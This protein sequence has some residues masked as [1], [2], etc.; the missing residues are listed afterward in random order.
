L[1]RS[2]T[3]SQIKS[4]LHGFLSGLLKTLPG[5]ELGQNIIVF[6]RFIRD[7]ELNKAV[8]IDE[9]GEVSINPSELPSLN[10]PEVVRKI[11]GYLGD[12]MEPNLS[13]LYAKLFIDAYEET[14]S[15]SQP[16]AD[17]WLG[18][19]MRDYGGLLSAYGVVDKLSREVNLPS[20]FKLMRP[21]STHLLKEEKP[22]ESYAM[23]KEAT[24]YGFR[25]VCVSKLEPS[26]V[27]YRYGLKNV[28]VIWLT[29][30]KTKEKTVSPD[31]LGELK[32]LI[33]NT[34]AGSV[35]L[36]D[37]LKEIKV[38]NGFKKAVD[39]L[40]EIIDL[41]V[42]NRLVLVVSIDPRSFTAEQLSALEQEFGGSK[43]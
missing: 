10:L 18:Q 35:I 43:T 38:V 34:G 30:R 25:L 19:I 42:K 31:K 14:R 40:R 13:N 23:V 9:K 6:D 28:T 17:I 26:K 20:I 41:C 39:F 36:F 1:T 32:L 11:L 37:C 33:S 27:K 24:R 22:T 2:E 21:G 16:A 4:S 5:K 15:S 8:F 12:Q 3:E 29:F 7:V